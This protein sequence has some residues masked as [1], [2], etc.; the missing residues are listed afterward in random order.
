M[1]PGNQSYEEGPKQ[2]VLVLLK[3][4]EKKYP[5]NCTFRNITNYWVARYEKRK[6]SKFFT[7]IKQ[8]IIEKDQQLFEKN[9]VE[10]PIQSLTRELGKTELNN[11]TGGQTPA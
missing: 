8:K 5:K 10:D 2:F 7:Q 11:T 9:S 6:N 3:K 1:F 4:Y